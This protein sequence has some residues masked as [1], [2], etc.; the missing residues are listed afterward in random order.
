MTA[1]SE[2]ERA[3]VELR[4]VKIL[5]AAVAVVVCM[6]SLMGVLSAPHGSRYLGF[7]FG[8]DD[9]MVYAAWMRQAMQGHILFD[10]RFTT[11]AQPGLT[12]HVY[13]WVLGL[14]AKVL[15]IP[16]AA[17]LVRAALS[18]ALVFLLHR[19]IRRVAPD[20][21]ATKLGLTLA[22]LGGGVGF[23]VWHNFGR[24]IVLP[25]SEWAK[26]AMLGLL[27]TDVWQPE[28]YAFPSMLV[29]GLFV[30]ALCLIVAVWIC[31]LD[32][33]ESWKPV[34]PGALCVALLMNAHSYDVLLVALV[35]VGF[36]FASLA[37]GQLSA[38]WVARA[39][40]IGAGAV[41]PALWFA[42]VL[43]ADRVFQARAATET[44]APNFRESFFG[45][46]PLIVL[47]LIGFGQRVQGGPQWR[48]WAGVGT[49][50]VLYS[51][52]FFAAPSN[53][54]GYFMSLP[55]WC[56]VFA[57][58]VA[59]VALLA[60]E[61]PAMNLVAAWAVVGM[62]APYFP[63]LFQRKL[64]MGLSVPWAILAAMA[65]HAMLVN[66]DRSMRNLANVLGIVVLAASSVRWLAREIGFVK[67][68]VSN[69]TV[70]P[71]FL[72]ADTLKIVGFLDRV[73]ATRTVVL[74]MPGVPKPAYSGDLPIADSFESPVVPDLNPILS[75]LTGVYTYA[76]H[77]S[78]T[79]D[80]G[81]RRGEET[82]FFLTTTAPE[83][84]EALLRGSAADYI[85]APNPDAFAG[86]PIAD[87]RSLGTVVVDGD[88]FRL[89]KVRR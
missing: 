48:Q 81:K 78:E 37:R 22:V 47:A 30:F 54:N 5:A 25:D 2:S 40:S 45:L 15:G 56:A 27:P 51:A 58:S 17:N 36:A 31:V 7:Q 52:L 38:I 29:N 80:Y 86:L 43:S 35:L 73:S 79:P 41:I 75:G 26:P 76:G 16:L 82:S 24:A 65:L 74:A 50:A 23:L 68:D 62:I 34:F 14:I 46:L 9:Q 88:R 71:V 42:H 49:L 18:A 59:S 61:T 67:Q 11:D 12:V 1:L 13:F 8:T 66:R 20:V 39:L 21:A 28:A 44:Y 89:I 60:S 87:L 3:R 70:Q 69:T 55:A 57:A 84:R 4:F 6:P 53:L 64:A 32:C 83:R 10:N 85:V 63:A 19:L 77:W 72:D 33:R